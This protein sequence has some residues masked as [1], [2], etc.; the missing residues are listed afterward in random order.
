MA[1][2]AEA[3]P[4]PIKAYSVLENDENTGSIYFARHRIEAHKAGANEFGDGELI[5]CT[6]RRASWADQYAETRD[7]PAREAV[8]HGWRFEC[9]DCGA[10]IA[11]DDLSER[12]MSVD[13]VIGSMF[14]LA[15][16][17]K[18]C[19]AHYH[20]LKRR[21]EVFEQKAIEATKD[22][23]RRRFGDVRFCEGKRASH[24]YVTDRNG[25]FHI[26]QIIVRF[27]FPGMKYGAAEF[28]ADWPTNVTVGQLEGGYTCCNGD[29][30]A[31]EAWARE[32]REPHHA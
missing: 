2:T 21:R 4:K 28:R 18:R 10:T 5:Y 6:C 22:I 23:V 27:E 11:E 19:A 15:F 24:I 3:P 16:C 30:D 7:I 1:S 32:T 31:F 14:G 13:G 8:T 26:G 20:G 17:S 12:S 29:R 9:A 25:G